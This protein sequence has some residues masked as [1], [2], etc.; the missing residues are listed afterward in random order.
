MI[1]TGREGGRK[2]GRKRFRTPGVA[3]KIVTSKA[4][5]PPPGCAEGYKQGGREEEE[6]REGRTLYPRRGLG[7]GDIQKLAIH[8]LVVQKNTSR[9]GGK[10]RKGGREELYIP[11]VASEKVTYKSLPSTSWL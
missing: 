5:H 1:Q 11:G 7:E 10:R 9:E 4:C 2:G 8:L 3:S 6:G